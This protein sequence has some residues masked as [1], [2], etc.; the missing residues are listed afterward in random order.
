MMSPQLHAVGYCGPLH[1][2]GVTMITIGYQVVF[3][4]K[5]DKFQKCTAK[6]WNIYFLSSSTDVRLKCYMVEC[7]ILQQFL[8]LSEFILTSVLNPDTTFA[9]NGK[10]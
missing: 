5:Q 10:L 6:L 3:P 7:Y 1:W 2:S 9:W 8:D 4:L